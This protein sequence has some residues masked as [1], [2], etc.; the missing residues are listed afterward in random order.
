MNFKPD[1]LKHKQRILDLLKFG[2]YSFE[3][4]RDLLN[5]EKNILCNYL[6][7]LK[8][9]KMVVQESAEDADHPKKRKYKINTDKSLAEVM[10]ESQS[11]VSAGV[12]KHFEKVAETKQA[13]ANGVRVIS[14]DDYHTF[15]NKGRATAWSGY[16]TFSEAI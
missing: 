3:E 6:T 12:K 13:V 11:K 16:T 7:S 4:I 15:G 8:K 14:S 5:L 9:N 10:A 1:T 2:T